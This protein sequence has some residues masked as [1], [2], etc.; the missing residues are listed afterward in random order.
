VQE[1]RLGGSPQVDALAEILQRVRPDVVLLN[2]L[3]HDEGGVA[4][5]LFAATLATGRGGA[6]GL[7]LSHA[8]VAPVNAGAPTGFDLDGDGRTDGPRDAHGF[9]RFEGQYGMAA[10]SRFPIG[11]VRT[12]RLLRRADM[13]G[14]SIP[15]GRLPPEA[16]AA[17]RLSSK[18]HWDVEIRTPDGPLRLLASHPTPPVFDGPEDANG[19]R[20]ADEI[21]FWV[22]YLS[23][24]G[25]MTDD[26]GRRGA[27]GPGPVVVLG[28]LNADP[29]DGDGRREA[30]A[31]LL[32]HPRLTD[33]GPGSEGGRA[34]SG[35][36][37]GA[38]HAG[39]PTR[40]TAAFAGPGP[41]RVDYVLPSRDLEVA[42]AGVFWPAP[43]DPL[44][45]LVGEGRPVV[46]S[47]HRLVWVDV[48]LP[49]R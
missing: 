2:E 21:R 45:R 10:L 48:R 43:G 46:S 16:E 11:A 6:A 38:A 37:P 7:E 1:L 30:I 19:R 40:D 18:S 20:N 39:D 24:D 23:G 34:A 13:P 9:G 36:G 5:R 8:F 35:T 49:A 31:A 47:D 14:A 3:D 41:L 33:P 28:D 27:A 4:A 12:F 25:W 29:A 17:L 26:A 44:R 22:D 15:P 32:A 42:G